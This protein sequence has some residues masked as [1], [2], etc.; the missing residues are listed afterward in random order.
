MNARSRLL[1]RKLVVHSEG[2]YDS[3]GPDGEDITRPFAAF[4]VYARS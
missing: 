4:R 3:F 2:H 1:L